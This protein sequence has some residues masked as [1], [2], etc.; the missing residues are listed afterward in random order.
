M[1]VPDRLGADAQSVPRSLPPLLAVAACLPALTFAAPAVTAQATVTK[2]PAVRVLF[3]Q[4]AAHGTLTPTQC[5]CDGRYILTLRDVGQ[6]TVWFSDRPSRNAGH[7][8]TANFTR[9]WSAYGFSADPPDAALSAIDA[10][11]HRRELV[12]ELTHPRYDPEQ[13]TMRY[14][15]RTVPH[16]TGPLKVTRAAAGLDAGRL[17]DV[18][19]FI[20]DAVF[21][22]LPADLPPAL[23]IQTVPTL[24]TR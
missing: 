10:S 16:T 1:L 14:A 3:T 9:G 23:A 12:A 15:A 24:P 11:G 18:S 19:L 13:R 17:H 22:V 20:D 5:K 21:P 2:P 4:T 7:I 8:A 6:D